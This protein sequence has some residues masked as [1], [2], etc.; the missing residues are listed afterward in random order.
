MRGPGSDGNKGVLRI[1][2]SSSN[3]ET[4]LSDCLVSYPDICWMSYPAAEMQPVYSA[5]PADSEF[6]VDSLTFNKLTLYHTLLMAEGWLSDFNDISTWLDLFYSEIF[7]N[8]ANCTFIFTFPEWFKTFFRTVIWYQVFETN[9][10]N[11]II[12]LWINFI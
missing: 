6:K 3:T 10:N 5:T 8:S 12:G 4:L 7:V 11:F 2:Q 1:P 9:A